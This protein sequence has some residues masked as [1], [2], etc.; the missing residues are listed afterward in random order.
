MDP[1]G[2]GTTEGDRRDREIPLHRFFG[3]SYTTEHNSVYTHIRTFTED[4]VPYVSTE[5]W[6]VTLPRGGPEQESKDYESNK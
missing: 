3:E 5:M 4:Q 2:V 1:E 6:I